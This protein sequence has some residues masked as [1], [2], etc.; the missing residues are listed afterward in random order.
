MKNK[1]IIISVLV[2]V[3]LI[4]LVGVSFAAYTYSRTGTT[5]SKQIVG[6]IY[7][8][9]AESN[10]LN[11][12]NAMPS[13]TFDSTKYFEFTIDGKNTTTNKT[14]WY[15]I[16]INRGDSQTGIRINDNLLK[17]KL[18][19]VINN[20]ETVLV[21]NQSYS[22]L[23]TGKRIYVA[24][25][26]YNTGAEVV[27]TYRLYMRISE[28][29][30]ICGGEQTGCD[31]TLSNW[32]QVYASIKV[33]V[34]GDF[35]EKENDNIELL[36]D[37]I[38][39]NLGSEGIVAVKTD[40]TLYEGTGEIRDYRYSGSGNYCTYTDGTNDYNFQVEG[41]TCPSKAYKKYGQN[42]LSTND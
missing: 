38:V 26:P 24:T 34:T 31:Y 12:T 15:D 29:T 28:R 42:F 5:N 6:D 33:N 10:S 35:T 32:N 23:S 9:Y 30:T 17:F 8:H 2:G 1:R 27:H 37:H 19:E 7:M 20:S 16:V 13:S 21:D 4:T 14:I 39:N 25:I 11:I 41:T 36:W 3:L 18:V 22:D 40:G